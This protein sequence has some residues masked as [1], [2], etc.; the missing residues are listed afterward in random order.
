MNQG[1]PHGIC[2]DL[3]GEVVDKYWFANFPDQLFAFRTAQTIC[4]RCAL[5]EAC[6]TDAIERP[7]RPL[8]IH[9]GESA[10]SIHRLQTIY[11]RGEV[12]AHELAHRAIARNRFRPGVEALR[13][14]DFVENTPVKN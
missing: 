6:L 9:G 1:L 5:Q 11:R 13:G 2:D 12:T 14:R 3:P 7:G 8:G 10:G 4:G